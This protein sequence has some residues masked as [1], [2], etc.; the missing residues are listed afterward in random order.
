VLPGERL[1]MQTHGQQLDAERLRKREVIVQ[2]LFEEAAQGRCYTPSQFAEAF[3]GT[4]G[5]GA[6]RT[7]TER[8]SVLA[9]KGYLKY[10]RNAADYDLPPLARSKY[11]YL[12]VEDM[13]LQLPHGAP[14]PETGELSTMVMPVRPTDYKCPRTGALL[15][16]ENPEVWIYQEELD[17]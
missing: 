1:V 9:T 10:F 17:T 7:I 14:D 5:L 3:E 15:P 13:V 2:I 16:V 8:L 12:C 11:G 4:A 6:N